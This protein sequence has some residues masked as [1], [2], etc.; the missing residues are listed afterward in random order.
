MNYKRNLEDE[1]NPDNFQSARYFLNAKLIARSFH[2]LDVKSKPHALHHGF[3]LH[4]E[5]G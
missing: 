2:I 1:D 5:K 4:F 3:P